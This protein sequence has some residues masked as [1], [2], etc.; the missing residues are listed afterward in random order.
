LLASAYQ[1]SYGNI[2]ASTADVFEAQYATG[3][4]SLLPTT[5]TR[6]E[7]YAQGA[8]PMAALFSSTPPDPTF[9]DIT[10]ATTPSDLA[11]VFALGFGAG[12]LIKNSY[13]LSFLQDA[14]VNPDGGWPTSTTGLAAAT[15][16]LALRLALQRNDLRNWVPTSPILLCGGN[17]DPL[18]FWLNTQL[19]QGYWASHAPSSAP[20]SVIDVDSAVTSGDP[21]ASVKTQFALARELVAATAVAQGATDGGAAAVAEAYHAPL[22][23]PFCLAAV[24]SFFA[25]Q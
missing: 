8:L 2:Y 22:V 24:E 7:L 23:P 6:S 5:V 21:Y 9:A 4:D 13:R 11:P 15:P 1:K 3:I 20:V 16:G 14:Q 25:A 10:P 18:V 17:A 19:M 12:N